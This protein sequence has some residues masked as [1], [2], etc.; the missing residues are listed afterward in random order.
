MT[1]FL[2]IFVKLEKVLIGK[3]CQG[4]VLGFAVHK[5]KGNNGGLTA[6]DSIFYVNFEPIRLK[7][8]GYSVKKSCF[9]NKLSDKTDF[10]VGGNC[11]A[12]FSILSAGQNLQ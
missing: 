9:E 11:R 5:G 6:S 10:V 12:E 4:R 2:W 7:Q 3:E 8:S 1:N